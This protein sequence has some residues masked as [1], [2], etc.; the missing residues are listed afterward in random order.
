MGRIKQWR[1]KRILINAQFDEGTW[2]LALQRSLSRTLSPDERD[3]L[4]EL[5]ILFLHEKHFSAA[6]SLQLDD[7]MRLH[8][9]VQACMLILNLGT[10]YYRGWS[11]IIMYPAEFVPRHQYTDEA[12]IVHQGDQA[13]A[14]EAWLHGP[15]I[16]SWA[17]IAQS[18]HPDGVNV[19]I[20]EFAHKLDM[21]NGDA[22]GYPPLHKD[23]IRTA[24]VQAFSDAYADFCP[25]VDRGE[26][27][28]I[29]P[30]AAESP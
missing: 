23:M 8:V 4:R 7:A 12:G 10:E 2:R 27:T 18:E 1:R 9:A 30:Y 24:W 16:L 11:E 17:D 21:L 22:N 25:R 15:V 28:V 29:D 19:V 3:R 20:H 5:T 14:G 6:H 26:D 13:F